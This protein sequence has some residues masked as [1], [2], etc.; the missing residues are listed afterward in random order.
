MI[1]GMYVTLMS[2][3]IAGAANMV[4]TKSEFYKKYAV[5]I[6]RGKVFH[7]GKRIFGENKTW[8]G[9]WGMVFFGAVFQLIWG[10]ICSLF[11]PLEDISELYI[12]FPNTPVY[13]LISGAFFGFAYVLF[14]LSNSFIKRRLNIASGKTGKGLLGVI[15][16]IVDQIDSLL[17]VVLVLKI[18]CGISAAKYWL[19]ILLGAF[20]HITVNLI[21]YILK[22]RKNI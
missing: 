22:I 3:I 10:I 2:V 17:G 7:D 12:F 11:K 4:F 9:F 18:L 14:E 20:T 21:L 16:F 15:F 19:Y 13:N 1:A 5:P 6:D 8:A